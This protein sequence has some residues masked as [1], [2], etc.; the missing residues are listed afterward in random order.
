M[1]ETLGRPRRIARRN[2]LMVA[3]NSPNMVKLKVGEH[4]WFAWFIARISV[5]ETI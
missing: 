5:V 4:A 2:K 3:K 1:G